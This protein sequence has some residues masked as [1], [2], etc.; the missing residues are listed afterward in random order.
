MQAI[1][2]AEY[3]GFNGYVAFHYYNEPQIYR[4]RINKVIDK[5]RDAKYLLWTNGTLLS[6]NIENN[7]ILNR[8]EKVVITCYDDKKLPLFNSLKEYYGNIQIVQWELDDRLNVYSSAHSNI[9]GCKRVQFKLP[10]DYY[11]NVHL[12]CRDWNNTFKMGNIKDIGL[13]RILEGEVYNTAIKPVSGKKLLNLNNC[14]EIC[15][16]CDEP[17]L[18][19]PTL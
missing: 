19:V 10:I 13:R 7:Q 5:K 15:K 17:W 12:C 6:S 14:P 18:R 16:S 1:N 4:D 11:G 2:D 9:I 3:F 8:F